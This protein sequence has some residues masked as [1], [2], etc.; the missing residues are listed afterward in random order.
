MPYF[1]YTGLIS[2]L[3]DPRLVDPGSTLIYVGAYV[4]CLHEQNKSGFFEGP[5]FNQPIR[6]I[7]QVF[8]N[9]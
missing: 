1:I 3:L 4:A 5:A 9:L 2:S 8:K 7:Y 6:A